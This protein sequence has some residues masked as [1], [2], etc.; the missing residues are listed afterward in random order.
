MRVLSGALFCQ[1]V[2]ICQAWGLIKFDL[3]AIE[4]VK[5]R[6]NASYK[7][8]KTLGALKRKRRS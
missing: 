3:L 8:R 1:V 5:L 2:G 7:Q 4:S 6:A